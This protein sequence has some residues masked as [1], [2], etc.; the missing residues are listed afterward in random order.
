MIRKKGLPWHLIHIIRA[1]QS[2]ITL[3]SIKSFER[4]TICYVFN[5]CGQRG[6]TV[7]AIFRDIPKGLRSKDPKLEK[8]YLRA[9]NAGCYHG[10]ELLLSSKKLYD[11]MG[12]LV[13]RVD[14]S[15]A[16]AGKR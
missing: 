7:A 3:P 1:K 14:F 11:E 4:R 12:V 16:Q 15:E 10:S 13:R 5:Y 6:R 9:D 8:V 2:S